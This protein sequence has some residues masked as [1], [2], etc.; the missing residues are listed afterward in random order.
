MSKKDFNRMRD[1]EIAREFRNT[2][3]WKKI[4][5]EIVWRDNNTCQ[6]CRKLPK[7]KTPINVH[8]IIKITEDYSRAY[9]KTNLICLCATCHTN[10]EKGRKC[11]FD[12]KGF[13][14]QTQVYLLNLVKNKYKG[15][16]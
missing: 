8:H 6:V 2:T 15:G 13:K 16:R 9:D 12:E 14:I 1:V 7:R 11:F 5:S 3:K 10:I 4:R